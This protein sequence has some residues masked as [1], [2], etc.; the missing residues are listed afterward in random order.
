MKWIAEQ[1][2]AQR[3][4]DAA[5]AAF[6]AKAEADQATFYARQAIQCT[7]LFR[8]WLHTWI[9]FTTEVVIRDDIHSRGETGCK[10]RTAGKK[11]KNTGPEK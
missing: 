10:N 6:R 11:Y 5:S 4:I 7:L 8:L 9:V 2:Q 1:Q 3:D